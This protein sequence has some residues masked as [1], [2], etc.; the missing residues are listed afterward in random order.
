MSEGKLHPLIMDLTPA[1]N[2][3]LNLDEM[4]EPTPATR[5]WK[6]R[7]VARLVA[8]ALV[9]FGVY[10]SSYEPLFTVVIL[11]II[12]VP[13]EKLF[14]RHKGQKVL[15]SKIST[16]VSYALAS[17]ILNIIGAIAA[18]VVAII[19]L[20][21]IPGLMIRPLVAMIPPM[22]APVVALVLFDFVVYWAHR[23]YHEVPFL[24]RFHAIHH[25]TEHLDWASG[26]R[27]H[28][29]DGT[30]IA[31]AFIF[32]IAAGFD[33]STAGIIAIVQILSGLFLH[34]NVKWRFRLL[35]K[36]NITPEF[37][38]WHHTNE[39]EAIWSNYSVFLPIWDL[40]FG[41]YYMP[42]DKR[43]QVYGVDE[44]IPDG[45]TE[46]LLHPLRGMG[47]PM[48]VLRHP[49]KATVLG[50]GST[51]SLL[52]QMWQSATRPRGHTPFKN[53]EDKQLVSPF[54]TRPVNENV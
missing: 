47:N 50:F 12:I 15:R 23:W 53:P 41:T 29:F 10:T 24:W 7:W 54:P 52:K 45:I 20:T 37:H 25:S 17:P 19:S 49:L 42:K 5:G 46:Q 8:L 28:P 43:P 30:L 2:S 13:F 9:G 3:H 40:I 39:A 44:Y 1:P 32:L 34:A 4:E 18:G 35:H 38:H 16:D 22:A 11:F 36:I 31:P 14:P 48:W 33:P 6:R 21:W 27:A 26:F 51:K